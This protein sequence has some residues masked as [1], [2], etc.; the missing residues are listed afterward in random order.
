MNILQLDKNTE[1]T[2]IK[3]L[4]TMKS[5]LNNSDVD[6]VHS[7]LNELSNQITQQQQQNVSQ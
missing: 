5:N 1:D 7:Q 2:V 6:S 4:T 3:H